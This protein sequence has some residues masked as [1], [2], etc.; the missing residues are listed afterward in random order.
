MDF[1]VLDPLFDV[2]LDGVFCGVEASDSDTE[3]KCRKI[4]AEIST[5]PVENHYT[6]NFTI[7]MK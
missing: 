3:K 7:D 4:S 1:G 2:D 6:E 5:F